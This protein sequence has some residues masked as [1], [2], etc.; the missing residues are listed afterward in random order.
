VYNFIERGVWISFLVPPDV[1]AKLGPLE[2]GRVAPARVKFT[3]PSWRFDSNWMPASWFPTHTAR[4]YKP[5]PL[6]LCS[7]AL[8]N[9]SGSKFLV[10]WIEYHLAIG[11]THL[12]LYYD[13][14]PELPLQVL[15]HYQRRGVVTAHDWGS[16]LN[17][18]EGF[19]F[20]GVCHGVVSRNWEHGQRIARNDCYLRYRHH[21][22]FMGFI[23]VD[24]LF[25]SATGPFADVVR[26]C[27]DAIASDAQKI[28]CSLT[29]VTVPPVATVP[30]SLMLERMPVSEAH[31]QEPYNCGKYHIGRAKYIMRTDVGAVMPPGPVF[32]HAVS[33]NY[34]IADTHHVFLPRSVG[35]I[36]HYAGHF[37]HSRKGG[38]PKDNRVYNPIPEF[39]LDAI[40]HALA[41]NAELRSLYDA[42]QHETFL[43]LDNF[44]DAWRF[45][46]RGEKPKNLPSPPVVR[47]MTFELFGGRLNNQIW[48]YDWVFRVALGLNRTAVLPAPAKREHWVGFAASAWAPSL[49]DV[50]RMRQSPVAFQFWYE[51]DRLPDVDPAC[52][53]SF[54]PENKH[55]VAW[56]LKV[57]ALPQC[58]S[59]IHFATADGL[60]HAYKADTRHLGVDPLVFWRFVQPSKRVMRE[61]KAFVK[62]VRG[63]PVVG[64]HARTF[65]EAKQTAEGAKGVC[66]RL[67]RKLLD[68]AIRRT[69][70]L[71]KCKC[72]AREPGDSTAAVQRLWETAH[73]EAGCS[74][75]DDTLDLVA[76]RAAQAA[77]IVA[78]D[79]ETKAMDELFARHGGHMH[80]YPGTL[81]A[82]DDPSMDLRVLDRPVRDLWKGIEPVLVDIAILLHVDVF[83]GTPSST[84][85][86]AVCMW[87]RALGLSNSAM[88]DLVWL[89]T[90]SNRC[91][92]M[93]P[94]RQCEAA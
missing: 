57:N 44:E 53:W 64:L 18:K 69:A 68:N 79:H 24:E 74:I 87:R 70:A 4:P 40:R 37:I 43:K 76:P 92:E 80:F 73:L 20:E 2:H 61:A 32:Y 62:S 63:K 38:L 54:S 60:V 86:Q 26:A 16:A 34:D 41:G 21:S 19:C 48:T 1:V 14:L 59:R 39:A 15:A 7:S 94:S 55:L 49:W 22:L 82:I 66:T 28:A 88:C 46:K 75:T 27:Q 36:R 13:R 42:P 33:Q 78:T 17:E 35:N 23:D 67:A 29:S 56:A 81:Q 11:F 10:E 93:E 8:W 65:L 31:C 77:F 91:D 71:D 89:S 52:R 5:E 30:G 72:R 6:V 84:L 58:A 85:S 3:A 50:R 25:Q 83:Y 45:A 51:V 9:M 12:V 90:F 47:Y